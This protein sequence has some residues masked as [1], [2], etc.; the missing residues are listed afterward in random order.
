MIATECDLESLL[1]ESWDKACAP[2]PEYNFDLRL[3]AIFSALSGIRYRIFINELIRSLPDARYL[4]VGTWTGST[5]CA[6]INRNKVKAVSIDNWSE[7][8]IETLNREI[9][10][11]ELFRNLSRFQTSDANV[12]LIDK[13]FRKVDFSSIGKFNV[14]MYDGSHSE[15]DQYDGIRL[16]LPALDDEFILIVDDWNQ[17][18][19][20]AGTFRALQDCNLTLLKNRAVM[21]RDNSLGGWRNQ[22][23][24]HNGYMI[25]VLRKDTSARQE[26]YA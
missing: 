4:E 10:R 5:L 16:A 6:A 12:T 11:E 24:W 14:Y 25:A 15:Q 26:K 13:D 23:E 17:S 18:D 1:V 3:L 9:V 20:A 7:F 2:D 22:G 21:L 8:F 19:V